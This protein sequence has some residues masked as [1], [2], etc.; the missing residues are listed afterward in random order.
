MLSDDGQWWLK[1]VK[2]IFYIKLA[3]LGATH[4]ANARLNLL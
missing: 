2:A 4:S 3:A 1:H